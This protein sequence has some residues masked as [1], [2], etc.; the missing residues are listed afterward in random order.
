MEILSKKVNKVSYQINCRTFET[1]YNWGHKVQLIV[2]NRIVSENKIVYYNR[3]WESFQYQSCITGA[4]NLYYNDL[5][6]NY[7]TQYKEEN[8]KKRLTQT[9]KEQLI[10][11]FK[12]LDN[13]KSLLKLKK[14]VNNSNNT[15][16]FNRQYI[17]ENF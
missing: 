16:A 12:K 9:E 1:R 4:I 6:N 3:T 2:N 10:K 5:F 8:D 11:D 13:V 14:I 17:N 15:N 7:I